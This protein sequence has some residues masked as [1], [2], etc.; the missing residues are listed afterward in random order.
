MGLRAPSFILKQQSRG[1]LWC[2]L[3]Q[4]STAV[5]ANVAPV[6][7]HGV[8]DLSPLSVGGFVDNLKSL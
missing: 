3:F 7:T 4:R 5:S 6:A 2:D 1:T 8:H